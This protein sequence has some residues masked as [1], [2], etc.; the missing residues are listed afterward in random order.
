M[1]IPE[2]YAVGRSALSVIRWILDT[3]EKFVSSLWRGS[4]SVNIGRLKAVREV[5]IAIGVHIAETLHRSRGGVGQHVCAIENKCNN[6]GFPVS[7]AGILKINAA[8]IAVQPRT[9]LSVVGVIKFA[10]RIGTNAS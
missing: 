7:V 8:I 5:H 3:H 6:P 1:E 4:G 2:V 9:Q 10:G